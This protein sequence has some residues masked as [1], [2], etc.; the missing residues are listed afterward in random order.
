MN[1]TKMEGLFIKRGDFW[2]GL[3]EV[4]WPRMEIYFLPTCFECLL[5][6]WLCDKVL[7]QDGVLSLDL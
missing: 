3:F 1:T 4:S 2:S 7:G 6:A 5:G